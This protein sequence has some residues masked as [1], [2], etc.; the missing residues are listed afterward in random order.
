[1]KELFV[2]FYQASNL[3]KG[4]PF[5]LNT[6]LSEEFNPKKPMP[7]FDYPWVRYNHYAM[8][9]PPPS[10]ELQLPEHL[11]FVVKKEKELLFDFITFKGSY[12]I[13]S[14]DFLE[15]LETSDVLK[16]YEVASL[17]VVSNTGKSITKKEYFALRFGIFDDDLINF[18]EL[19]KL[20]VPNL[21]SRFVYEDIKANKKIE[22]DLFFVDNFCYQ[23]TILLTEKAKAEIQK[24]FYCPIIY[25]SKEF[26][27]AYIQDNDW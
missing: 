17:T 11:F 5:S 4:V 9:F 8:D 15:Y 13:V 16:N 23:E 14:K 25:S 20:A 6:T 1:M 3:P 10:P 7:G 24:R 26:T 2:W 18:N 12:K 22:R 21:R 19:S 27:T